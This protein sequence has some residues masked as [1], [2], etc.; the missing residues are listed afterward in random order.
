MAFIK[1]IIILNEVTK[2][3]GKSELRG[4]ATVEKNGDKAVC[5]LTVFNL[6]DIKP[7]KFLFGIKSR[8]LRLQKFELNQSSQ[9]FPLDKE[10]D[11][12]G[13]ISCILAY[14]QPERA[15]PLLWGS[16]DGRKILEGNMTDGL[17]RPAPIQKEEPPQNSPLEGCPKGGVAENAAEPAQERETAEKT[18][19][20]EKPKE[21]EAQEA[22]KDDTYIKDAEPQENSPLEKCPKGGVADKEETAA[23]DYQDYAVAAENFYPADYGEALGNGDISGINGLD[24]INALASPLKGGR[25][26]TA[27]K[28]QLDELFENYPK[29]E[30]L[31]GLLKGTDWVKVDYDNNGQYYTVGLIAEE[32][33]VK[34]ICYGVPGKYAKTPPSELKGFCQWLPFDMEKP[35]EQGYW[36]MYQDAETGKSVTLEVI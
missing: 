7:G 6:N 33:V 35:E 24:D 27:I 9:N 12:E 20:Q 19:E 31:C 3:Y 1:K 36:M 10:T 23:S 22:L 5:R 15:V 4:L 21:P 18:K 8:S 32:D 30:Y 26:Y 29:E 14:N 28:S 13:V 25:F 34:Y 17:T 16:T 11:I 2:G